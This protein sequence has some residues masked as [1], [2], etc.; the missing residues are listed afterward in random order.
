VGFIRKNILLWLLLALVVVFDNSAYAIY[1]HF[2]YVDITLIAAVMLLIS[3][4]VN[5]AF[6]FI[7]IASIIHEFFLMPF[8]GLLI[9]SKLTALLTGLML[10]TSLYRNNYSTRVV[11]LAL[12]EVTK[13]LVYMVLV[14]IFYTSSKQLVFPFFLILFKSIVTVAAG[15][16]IMKLFDMN[17]DWAGI[18]LKKTFQRK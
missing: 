18:W 2:H 10:C 11:I 9:V 7:V 6:V 12:T 3:D 13:Q 8:S 14:F 16:A 4:R 15:A 1:K 17:Y 5:T